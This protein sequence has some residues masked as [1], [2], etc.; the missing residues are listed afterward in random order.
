MTQP[1]QRSLKNNPSSR[2]RS[3]W[4]IWFPLVF[5]I[6]VVLA[7][8]VLIVIFSVQDIQANFN[9][10]WANISMVYLIIPTM[11]T[12]FIFLAAIVALI[13]GIS[14]VLNLLPIYSKQVKIFIFRASSTIHKGA[15]KSVQPFLAIHSWIA[16]LRTIFEK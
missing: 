14:K 16:S 6:L 4:Q 11:F 13:Y 5:S 15:N 8:A 9:V 10:K 1:Q 7:I 3:F 12:A 2:K